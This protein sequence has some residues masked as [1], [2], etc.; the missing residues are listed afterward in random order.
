M[1]QSVQDLQY[2][3][4]HLNLIPKTYVKEPKNKIK[5]KD[6]NRQDCVLVIPVLGSQK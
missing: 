5:K 3:H 2:K 6:E 4:E 1:T